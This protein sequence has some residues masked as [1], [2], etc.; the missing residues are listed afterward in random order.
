MCNKENMYYFMLIHTHIYI[1]T[2]TGASERH[3]VLLHGQL[4]FEDN[5]LTE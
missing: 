1:F 5:K 2:Y 4:Q 3:E